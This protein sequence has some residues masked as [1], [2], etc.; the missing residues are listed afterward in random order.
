MMHMDQCKFKTTVLKSSWW[1]LHDTYILA[2]GSILV[3][4]TWATDAD[5]NNTNKEVICN[6]SNLSTIY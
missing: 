1:W 2:K 4:T 6:V 3:E 5:A